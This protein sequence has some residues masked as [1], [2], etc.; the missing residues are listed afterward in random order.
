VT[1]EVRAE[2]RR[3]VL[4]EGWK[5]ETVARRFGV[6]HSTVRRAL[7]D[8]LPAVEDV[9]R[10]SALD[11]FKPYIVQRLI[12]LPL[13]SAV[14]LHAELRERGSTVGI[15]Q[16]RRYA[17]LVRPPRL[18]KVYLRV[19]FEPGEQA[20]VDWALFGHM[21]VGATQRKL[22]LFSMVLSWS[23]AIF[24]DFCF[25]QRMETF[26]RMHRRALEF[27]GGVPKRIVYDNLKS[28]VVDRVGST[29]K[30]N[31][32]FLGFAG[33]YL[34]EA[35]AAPVRYPQFKGRV[36]D[37]V[38]YVRQS[39]FYGR[40]FGS[41]ADLRAQAREWCLKTANQRLHA[42]T[43][44]RPSE[45]LLVE[46]AR[47][48]PLPPHPFD[49]DVVMPLVVTK[50]ACVRFD[51]NSYSVPPE[52]VGK[53]VHLRADD[54]TVRVIID[55][56]EV[57]RH[58]RCWDR[59]RHIEDPAHLE[60]LLAHRKAARGPKARE[61]LFALCPEARAYLHEVARRKI[62]LSHEVDKLL[63]L[64]DLYGDSDVSLAIAR[65]VADRSFGA[66]FVRA[67]CDQARFARREPEPP[68]PIV[69]GNPAADEMTV[70][71]H[72]MESYD[73]LFERKHDTTDDDD[74]DKNQ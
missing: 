25:D 13:L 69:T 18:K 14:R 52:H 1:P 16:M 8:D 53:T 34:F 37:S 57:A 45:R 58:A 73:A 55:G 68:D 7:R 6:H 65:A 50:E 35:T 21:R 26:C 12:E 41:L 36:E 60:S 2:I 66:R 32:R 9:R 4:R 40:S 30:F 70:T 56:A 31:A 28:V 44:E 17:A 23:R 59:R 74:D 42:T 39:F 5:I 15:A 19:E 61:R 38:K 10:P 47:L 29:I 62:H 20:Q 71:P 72:D 33:H 54:D 49:T 22:S 63:R 46:H 3:L 48:R 43:R 27:F 51:A 67:L 24:V 11:P 64:I